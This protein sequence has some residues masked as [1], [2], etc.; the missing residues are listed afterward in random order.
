[1]FK[2]VKYFTNSSSTSSLSNIEDLI[3]SFSP[4]QTDKSIFFPVSG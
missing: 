4:E 2:L 3:D 1:M